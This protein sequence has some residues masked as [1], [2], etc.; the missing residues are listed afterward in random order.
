VAT[1]TKRKKFIVVIMAIV[2]LLV[3]FV[4]FEAVYIKYNGKAGIEPITPRG[5]HTLGAGPKLTYV[6]M[7]DSTAVTQG[8]D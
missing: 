2:I 7:G 6:V 4:A 8:G 1:H 3:L 5:L